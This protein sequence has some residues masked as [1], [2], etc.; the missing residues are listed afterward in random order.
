MI[1]GYSWKLLTLLVMIPVNILYAIFIGKCQYKTNS[2][3]LSRISQLTGYLA[4][5]LKNL[6][7]IKSFANEKAE[8]ANGQ[9][10]IKDLYK[11]KVHSVYIGS[12][13]GAFT[14]GTEIISIIAEVL[15]VS[16]LL[17]SGEIT[18]LSLLERMYTPDTGV[19]YFGQAPAGEFSLSAWRRAFGL[20][21]QDR[22][23]LEGTLRE[24]ITYGCQ[25]D[26]TDEEL[27]EAART[28]P[29]RPQ[30]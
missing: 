28:R 6:S 13:H 27:W 22:P 3:I 24:N 9:R 30:Q 29:S 2:R 15:F 12:T 1:Q 7:L 17:R 10:T 11:A 20:V 25:R 21:A 16:G 8:D 23:V 5:W 4:E 14:I 18:I 19:V 26:I